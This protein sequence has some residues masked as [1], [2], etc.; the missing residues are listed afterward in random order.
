MKNLARL[1]V[2]VYVL[3]TG[4]V[5]SVLFANLTL[6]SF[7]PLPYFGQLSVGTIFFAAVFTLRDRIHAASGLSPVYFAIACA[8]IVNVV[9]A[10]MLGTPSRF[11][12]ASFLAIL[13]SELADTAIF[14]QLRDK[15]WGVRVLSSN[16]VSVPLD[17]VLFTF[18]AFYGIESIGFMME[19]IYADIIVKYLISVLFIV[20]WKLIG[21]ERAVIA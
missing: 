17:T 4:Y 19:I 7:I 15:K 8:L 14:Q 6:N 12:I 5:L 2:G 20:R 16:A 3:I 21:K 9:T 10:Y 11:I 13:I 1:P 18:L